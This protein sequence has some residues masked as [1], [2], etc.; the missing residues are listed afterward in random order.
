MATA[1]P[2]E[3][4]VIPAP[5]AEG[6][7][8]LVYEGPRSDITYPMKVLYCGECS[9]PLEFC[10]YYPNYEKCKKWL[11]TNLPDQFEKLKA[12]GEDGETGDAEKKRQKRGGKGQV[13]AKKKAEPQ[14]VNLGYIKRGKKKSTIITGLSTYEIDL[15]EAS[16]FFSKK[17][18]CGSSVV[19][20]DEISVQGDKRDDLFDILC[21]KWP[22]IDEDGIDDIGE[23]K[24]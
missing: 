20:E 22:Q 10:E 5:A 8:Y 23:V 12:D 2:D 24:R 15:K 6:R 4:V 16:Q 21:E 7:Q 18:S 19:A 3:P 14:G 17:F 13:K 1:V 11:E 9:M